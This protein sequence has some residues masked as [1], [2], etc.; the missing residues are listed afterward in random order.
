MGEYSNTNSPYT[1]KTGVKHAEYKSSQQAIGC[2]PNR[3]N[4]FFSFY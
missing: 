4:Q 3:L 2:P 1:G